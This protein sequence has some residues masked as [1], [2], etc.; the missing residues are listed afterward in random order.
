M[1]LAELLPLV[2]NLS[3]PDKARLFDYLGTHLKP[4]DPDDESEA[5]VLD[6]L[7]RSLQQIKEGKVHPIAELWEGI[8][9]G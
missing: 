2:D 9:V 4:A 5:M 8:D 7:R 3:Q 6:S 1:S